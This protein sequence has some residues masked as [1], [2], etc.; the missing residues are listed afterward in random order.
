MRIFSYAYWLLAISAVFLLLERLFPW[1]KG[2]PASAPAGCETS[3][4]SR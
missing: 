1:R 2:Q 3:G 4:S